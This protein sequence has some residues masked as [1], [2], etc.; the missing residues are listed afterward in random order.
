MAG[1][2]LCALNHTVGGFDLHPRGSFHRW[3]FRMEPPQVVQYR[4]G[5]SEPHTLIL[6][7]LHQFPQRSYRVMASIRQLGQD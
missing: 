3:A 5:G 2:Q 6:C 4:F 1:G 7:R